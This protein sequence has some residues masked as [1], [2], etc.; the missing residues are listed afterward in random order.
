MKYLFH[1]VRSIAASNLGEG[2]IRSKIT[3]FVS[4]IIAEIDANRC[5]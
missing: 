4:S 3:D 5:G 2:G 1:D